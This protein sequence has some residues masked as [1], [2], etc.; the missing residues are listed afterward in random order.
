[1]KKILILTIFLLALPG[2]SFAAAETGPLLE[3][4]ISSGGDD[5]IQPDGTWAIWVYFTDKGLEENLISTALFNAQNELSQ[6]TLDRRARVKPVGLPPVDLRDVP[7]AAQYLEAVGA[8]GA[9][10]RRNSRWLNAASF[11]ADRQQI[12]SIASLPFV[13]KVELVAKFFRP[14]S[15]LTPEEMDEVRS[16]Q[17]ESRDKSR[18]LWSLDYGLSTA[19][20]EMINVPQ[21]HELGLTGN[22]VIIAQLD[23]GF[24]LTHE[25]LQHI[26]ILAQYD[27]VHDDGNVQFEPGDHAWQHRHGTQVLSI[28]MGFKSGGI[29]GPAFGASVILAMTEDT[30]S[31]TPIEEDNWVA[32]VEWV[33]GLGADMIASSL[34]YY[35]WYEYS[36]LDGDTAV[37]TVAADMAVEHGMVVVTS[38]GNQRGDEEWPYL[39]APADGDSVLACAAVDGDGFIASFSSP[40]PTFDG[41]IKPDLSAQGVA[42]PMASFESDVNFMASNGTSF[43]APQI[44]GVVALLLERNPTLTPMQIR[45]ALR[46]TASMSAS[47]NNDFGWGIIDAFAAASY[48][49]A[50]I[51]HDSLNDTEDTIGPYTVSATITSRVGLDPTNIHFEYR[52]DGGAWISVALTNAGGDIFTADIPGQAG[53]LVEY[54]LEAADIDGIVIQSPS[55]GPSN[56]WS[57]VIGSDITP[58]TLTHFGLPN[59]AIAVWPPTLVANAADNIAMGQVVLE[60]SL[61]DGPFQGP[62]PMA[63]NGDTYELVF[64]LDVTE[65]GVGDLIQYNL[66]AF[67]ATVIPNSTVSGPWEF[68]VLDSLGEVLVIDESVYGTS[69]DKGKSDRTAGTEMAQWLVEMGYEVQVVEAEEVSPQVLEGKDAVFLT[70]SNNPAPLGVSLMR[71]YLVDYVQ[72]GG[73][74][75]SEGGALADVCYHGSGY[76]EFANTVLRIS[77]YIGDASLAMTTYE[78]FE[79]HPVLV[80]PNNLDIPIVHDQSSNPYDLGGGD[81]MTPLP[82]ANGILHSLY[83]YSYCRALIYD[84]NTGPEA[85]QIV[86]LS[87]ALIYLD[88]VVAQSLLENSMAYLLALEA[89]GSASISGTVT[90]VGSEDA[91]GVTIT[92]GDGHSAISAPDGSFL[93]HGLHGSNYT[94][95]ATF[96]GYGPDV[97]TIILAAGESLA[98]VDFTLYPIVES[99]YT[100]SPEVSIPDYN[101]TGVSSIMTIAEPGIVNSLNIDINI[102]HAS[103][104]QLEIQLTSPSGTTVTLHDFTGGIA[105]DIVG[106]WPESLI[107]DGPGSLEDFLNEPVLGDWTLNVA[108]HNFGATGIFHSWGLNLLV[109]PDQLTPVHD[110]LPAATRLVGNI[111]NPFNPQT[112]IVFD[113]AATGT[114]NL[115][116][117]DVRGHRVRQLLREQLPA[118]RHEVLWNGK[119]S[120]GRNVASGVYYCRMQTAGGSQMIKMALVR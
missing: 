47:P 88:P 52:V 27:F 119:D 115:E 102:E 50:V 66:T 1:M 5:L 14:D 26:P 117:F 110:A 69:K 58:P 39:T 37:T 18:D 74:I 12:S 24:R 59:Q 53:G 41:R 30:G 21:V 93:I 44:A 72:S 89:P 31:E 22:G 34:G 112:Q 2:F 116:L 38:A 105:D 25:C 75:I 84:N 6:R 86:Y 54:F 67:D 62:F 11:N 3:K 57:F 92:S 48:W 56:P 71:A 42:V 83:N 78:G 20:L 32:A 118:G 106:N 103:I 19:N 55:S 100:A 35:Y 94:L 4:A 63:V 95:T 33:E 104:G 23:S 81:G 80:R 43:S 109:T 85:G 49:G 51:L 79:N 60:F 111:P 9:E 61:N 107:V 76:L 8:S 16:K 82:D 36:D 28:M 10:H 40:G 17:E 91:S 120:G 15:Q 29:V 101:P 64:P 97:E 68:Q 77:G 73:K 13:K 46:E 70:C 113:L 45:E 99:N 90:L 96:E 7:V 108:D 98:G 87:T 114:V 65:I